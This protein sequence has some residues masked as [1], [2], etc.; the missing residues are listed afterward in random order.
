MAAEFLL[1]MDVGRKYKCAD[2]QLDWE[3]YYTYEISGSRLF[4]A[5]GHT[6]RGRRAAK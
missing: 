4:K 1:T 6:R 5:G 2:I 3:R